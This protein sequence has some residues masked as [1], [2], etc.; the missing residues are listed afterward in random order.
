[1]WNSIYFEIIIYN[2]KVSVVARKLNAILNWKFVEKSFK[3]LL[4]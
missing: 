3:D 4:I 1:M 2:V